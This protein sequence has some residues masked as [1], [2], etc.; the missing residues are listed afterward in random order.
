M[1]VCLAGCLWLAA[2]LA[3]PVGLEH[4]E[5]D[6]EVVTARPAVLWVEQARL[7]LGRDRPDLTRRYAMR[8]IEADE[9]A[10]DAWRLYLRA[11]AEAGLEAA[12]EAELLALDRPGAHVTVAWWKVA[13]GRA[14]P[15]SLLEIDDPRARVA[16]GYSILA[17][18]RE[19]EVL[20]LDL[21]DEPLAVR[22][23]LRA[24]AMADDARGLHR[25]ALAW[26]KVHPDRPDVLE[27]LWRKGAPE[28]R[29]RKKVL[30]ALQRRLR[31]EEDPSWLCLVIRPLVQ[32][33][34]REAAEDV[35][36]QVA[37]MGLLA[38]LPRK[39][40]GRSM[41]KAMGK[42]LV[43][44]GPED[45]PVGS[46]A[47]RLAVAWEVSEAWLV[48]DR[49]EDALALW[50][51]L[52]SDR[53]L[54]HRGRA[55]V[56]DALG[57]PEEARVERDRA[58][59]GALGPWT[60]DPCGLDR[61]GRAAAVA[62]VTSDGEVDQVLDQVARRALA[63]DLDP[64]RERL[65]DL[66][67]GP[68]REELGG[69]LEAVDGEPVGPSWAGPLPEV[70]ATVLPELAAEAV[71]RLPDDV[72]ALAP[73]H[74]GVVAVGQELPALTLL[75][76]EGDRELRAFA[77]E[78][79]PMVLTLWASWCG[80][81]QTELPLMDELVGALRSDGVAVQA[82]AI[83]IDEDPRPYRR[84]LQRKPF[85]HL[86]SGRDPTLLA[87]LGGSS[88]PVTWVVDDDAVVQLVHVGH[89]P[90]LPARVEAL[91]RRLAE[92]VWCGV[93]CWCWP[94]VAPSTKP[95]SAAGC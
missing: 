36:E 62:A 94:S 37:S 41:R 3:R 56:L 61:K 25:E 40:W 46:E 14:E 13:N 95:P 58:L 65:E 53:W 90:E 51:V 75:L 86:Q 23:R 71:A 89:D 82:A 38:P 1:N 81:C 84:Q 91:V 6:V 63:G 52:D 34:E 32:A 11:S 27:E 93:G 30:K 45:L 74:R 26:L 7:A 55:R 92:G 78:D 17:R 16:W 33:R 4:D 77:A 64:W 10:W 2:A 5:A 73:S 72:Q 42:A 21:P 15:D 20:E 44:Q 68:A 39:P 54:A 57:R 47:E 12:A 85:E 48:R 87:A 59:L 43:A 69:C 18:G 67:A 49:E 76:D 24:L 8:A 28:T 50:D 19:L 60:E 29:A 31:Q 9:E 83:S 35:A 88:L 22:L 79:G 70:A 80:P 66:P